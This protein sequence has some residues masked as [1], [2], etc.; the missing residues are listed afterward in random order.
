M[1]RVLVIA[2]GVALL[3]AAPAIAKRPIDNSLY[4]GVRAFAY[5]VGVVASAGALLIV[6]AFGAVPPEV[7]AYVLIALGLSDV[8][9]GIV[10]RR[11][12]RGMNRSAPE[13]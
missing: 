5:H 2:V 11:R 8:V 10:A 12:Q 7:I 4:G 3:A 1:I 9:V 6:G 13:D